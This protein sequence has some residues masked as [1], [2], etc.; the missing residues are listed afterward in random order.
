M[1]FSIFL[2]CGQQLAPIFIGIVASANA[3]A[4]ASVLVAVRKRKDERSIAALALAVAAFL[5][6]AWM[7]PMGISGIFSVLS[8]IPVVSHAPLAVL[9]VLASITLISPATLAVV[10]AILS[11]RKAKNA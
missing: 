3:A 9:G 2:A 7:F 1:R 4:I 6:G 11:V 5:P 8:S 10:G